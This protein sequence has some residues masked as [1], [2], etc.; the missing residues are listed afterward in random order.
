M[1]AEAILDYYICNGKVLST[2]NLNGFNKISFSSIYEVIRIID[3]IPLYKN[4]H[5]NRMR[6]SAELLGYKINKSNSE[7]SKEIYNLIEINKGYNLNIKI[8]SSNPDNQEQ[9]LLVYFVKSFYPSVENYGNGVDTI[10]FHSYRENPHVKIVNADIRV[11]V[12]IKIKEEKVFEALLVNENGYITEGSRSNIFFVNKEKIYTAPSGKVLL[13]ITRKKILQVCKDLSFDIIEEHV[14]IDQLDNFDGVFMSGTSV[15]ILPI[16][17]IGDKRY[18]SSH[19]III[20]DIQKAYLKNV[21][22][23]LNSMK[24]FK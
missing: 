8:V 16:A 22:E 6:K 17:T 11:K 10:L 23:Y 3:G 19:N 18:N 14:H 21:E 12:N 1:K 24:R 15:G 4:D 2:E 20:N 5:I 13:G 7:I 9:I